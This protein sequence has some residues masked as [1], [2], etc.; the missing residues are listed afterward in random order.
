MGCGKCW[1]DHNSSPNVCRGELKLAH[2]KKS[3][4]TDRLPYERKP[5]APFSFTGKIL[6][7]SLIT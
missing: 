5:K 7:P 1:G 2:G 3:R 6:L 4:K